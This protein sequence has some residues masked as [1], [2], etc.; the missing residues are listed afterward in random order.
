MNSV[1]IYSNVSFESNLCMNCEGGAIYIENC[2]NVF[3]INNNINFYNNYAENGGA[4]YCT[5]AYIIEIV[6]YVAFF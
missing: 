5:D 1:Y 2:K 3:S 4:I 6:N